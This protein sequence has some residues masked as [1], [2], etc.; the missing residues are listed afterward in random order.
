MLFRTA[1]IALV[2]AAAG[3]VGWR[4]MAPAG[5]LGTGLDITVTAPE[6]SDYFMRGATIYQMT[7]TGQ[8]DYRMNIAEILHYPDSS[9]RLDD[10]DARYESADSWWTLQAPRGLI[11][12]NS[13]DIHLIG[14][15]EVTHPQP[16]ADT[17]IINTRHAWFRS[18]QNLIETDAHATA[19]SPG[20]IAEGDGLRITLDNDH[21]K[22]LDNVHVRYK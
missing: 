20:R 19:T 8:L 1:I 16:D 21:M 13:R 4:I 11:P 14:G 12:P 5:G 9:A 2:I 15:V 7:A 18:Q 6:G 22:L 3:L 10:I 17:V